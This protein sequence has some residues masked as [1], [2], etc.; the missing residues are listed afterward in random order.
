MGLG[1]PSIFPGLKTRNSRNSVKTVKKESTFR[2]R[3]FFVEI[4]EN[5]THRFSSNRAF[6]QKPPKYPQKPP[7][8]ELFEKESS[9]KFDGV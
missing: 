5:G 9:S 4:W 8:F 6:W 3:L 7:F 2:K 1:D